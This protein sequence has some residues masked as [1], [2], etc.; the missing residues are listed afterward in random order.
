[1]NTV[2]DGMFIS[3]LFYHSGKP[4]NTAMNKLITILFVTLITYG[5]FALTES[6]SIQSSDSLKSKSST[7]KVDP[8][9]AKGSP[10]GKIAK[11]TDGSKGSQ[12][13]DTTGRKGHYMSS[14]TL[15]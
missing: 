5:A 15:R 10:Q 4:K 14:D 7:G 3:F 9:K 1:V 2:P 13:R 8:N 6:L 12:P 11:T